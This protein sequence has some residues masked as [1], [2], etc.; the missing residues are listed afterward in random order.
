MTSRQRRQIRIL[1]YNIHGCIGRGGRY[2]AEAVLTVLQEV[3]A[4]FVALQE[5]YDEKPQDRQFL[6]S[7]RK[8]SYPSIE[9]GITM[10]HKTRGA[11]GNV[12]LS[13]WPLKSVDKIDLSVQPFEPRGA[14]HVNADILGTSLEIT[15]THLGLNSQ[16]RLAQ[17]SKIINRWETNNRQS[18]SKSL[19]CLV[20]DLNEWAPR[21]EVARLLERT[22][23]KT[24]KLRT[25]P[26]RFPTFAL[27]RILVRPE[28]R[29]SKLSVINSRL[30]RRA[31]D[32]LPLVAELSM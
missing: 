25:F 2:D 11:Y 22:F 19:V 31:S 9:Y 15:A 27:D 5:V 32:H 14:I 28:T 20:G 12:F 17:V 24:R 3:E 30:T 4:D 29:V 23:G 10:I 7:L 6:A 8:L 21:G 26:A 1:T 18:G 16:E 13:K